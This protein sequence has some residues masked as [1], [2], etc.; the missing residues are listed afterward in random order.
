MS[1]RKGWECSK[2]EAACSP[3][4]KVCPVCHPEH[5]PAEVPAVVPQIIY[6]QPYVPVYEPWWSRRQWPDVTPEISWTDDSPHTVWIAS[7]TTGDT[8]MVASHC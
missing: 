4:V 1:E 5:E 7:E 3:D 8:A 2:C 6:V